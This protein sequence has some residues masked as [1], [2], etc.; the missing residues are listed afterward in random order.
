MTTVRNNIAMQPIVCFI[1][2]TYSIM[3]IRYNMASLTLQSL[4][5][6]QGAMNKILIILSTNH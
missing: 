2:M 1:N 4:N 6:N 5:S 3:T